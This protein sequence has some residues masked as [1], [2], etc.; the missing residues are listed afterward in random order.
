MGVSGVRCENQ[1][2][3]SRIQGTHCVVAIVKAIYP[4]LRRDY[5]A[6]DVYTVAQDDNANQ[7]TYIDAHVMA[8]E[9][10]TIAQKRES[11]KKA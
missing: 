4:G 2:S 3:R 6:G 7:K 11:K 10:I 1:R 9:R 8:C 5:T